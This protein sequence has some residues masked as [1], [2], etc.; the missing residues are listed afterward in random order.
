MLNIIKVLL[1]HADF[2]RLWVSSLLSETGSAF[3]LVA[4]PLY[5]IHQSHSYMLAGIL[6]TVGFIGTVIMRIPG[7]FIGDRWPRRRVLMG[8]AAGGTMAMLAVVVAVAWHPVFQYW[9]IGVA[10]TLNGFIGSAAA[11]VQSSAVARTLSDADAQKGFAAWQAQY[12]A[13]TVIGPL[14]GGLAFTIAHTLPFAIDA[15]S[16]LLELIVL[17]RI[18]QNLGEGQPIR[19]SSKAVFRGVATV[20]HDRFL[21]VYAV[22]NGVLNVASQGMLYGM[23]FW[24]T[25]RGGI[26]V[27]AS[28]VVLAV[29]SLV[30]TLI[31]PRLASRRY[32][33]LLM[34]CVGAYA[35]A[36]LCGY[37]AS[38]PWVAVVGLAAA[39]LI[40]QPPSVVLTS[41]IMTTVPDALRARV[42]GALFLIGSALYPFGAIITGAIAS[43][44]SINGAFA[45]WGL[46]CSLP[47]VASL[48]PAWQLP[49]DGS[50]ILAVTDW[51]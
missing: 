11:V 33:L 34:T 43:S 3:S 20:I 31:A 10:W 27:G 35:L 48:V 4:L 5:V 14:L 44:W 29:G 19:A 7:G 30:G 28:F 32:H 24:M 37:L 49:P 8:G 51:M 21:V 41:H 40:C 1:K 23:V 13:T 2:R 46:V 9:L 45:V 36:G 25:R 12:A 15:L 50:R 26:A 42:Q 47:L 38:T 22:T 18:R 6:T 39:T 17:S 16:F